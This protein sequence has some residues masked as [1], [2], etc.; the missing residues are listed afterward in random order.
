[1]WISPSEEGRTSAVRGGL[2]VALATCAL[3][4]ATEP[5]LA[6]VWDEGYTLGRVAR[7]RAWFQR[8]GDPGRSRCWRDPPE[9][10]LVQPD[11]E[12]APRCLVRGWNSSQ[13][14]PPCCARR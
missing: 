4:L 8:L 10:D 5:R 12:D 2:L 9:F 1:M 7:V 14:D 11:R 3:M 6:I 13:A